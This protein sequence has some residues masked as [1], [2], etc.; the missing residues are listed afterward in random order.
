MTRSVSRQ[1]ASALEQ[2]RTQF[3]AF[4]EV[5]TGLSVRRAHIAPA[6]L[7]LF[8]RYRQETGRTFVAFVKELD[9]TV[10]GTKPGYQQHRSYQA[11][12]Y[13]R[14]LAEAPHTTPQHRKTVTPYRLLVPVTK[15]LLQ[16]HPHPDAVW[17]ALERA[18]KWNAR[19][20]DRF[21]RDV[22]RT[23]PLVPKPGAPRLVKSGTHRS[24]AAAAADRS[25]RATA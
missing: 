6:F 9:P 17:A 8:E 22:A 20:V 1:L 25:H 13:L 4:T 18:S 5:W 21:R 10:P 19:N 15:S 14:R 11:A 7:S 2:L 12:L 24:P 3:A 23:E 16:L